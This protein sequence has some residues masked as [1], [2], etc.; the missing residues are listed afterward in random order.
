MA[1]ESATQPIED[2]IPKVDNEIAVG[3]DL[4]FQRRWWKWEFVAWT[5][6]TVLIIA[7][8]AGFLGRGYFSKTR[9]A[10]ADGAIQVEYE[11]VA[12]FGAPTVAAVTFGPAAI[13]D[14]KVQLWANQSILREMGTQRVIP[15]PQQASL[16]ENG[17][18]FTFA[19]NDQVAGA[20]PARVQF[21]LQ[22]TAVG[23]QTL[24]LG[25]PGS[26]TVTAKVLV[27]P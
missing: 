26:P 19:V 14:G 4:E 22:P 16:T 25:S 23:R 9:A 17:T 15:Q 1:A 13:H 24:R 5:I 3:S 12:R 11:R 10:S 7:A 2:S 8:V 27:L 21:M 6:F 18:L 20:T